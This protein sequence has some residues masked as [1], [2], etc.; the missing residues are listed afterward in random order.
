MIMTIDLIYSSPQTAR[1]LDLGKYGLIMIGLR[2]T[3]WRLNNV[4]QVKFFKNALYA[5]GYYK[6]HI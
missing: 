2:L 4:V 3:M 5:I 1:L 6:I